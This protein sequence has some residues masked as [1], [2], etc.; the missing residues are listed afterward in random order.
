[1]HTSEP[2]KRPECR[3]PSHRVFDPADIKWV[4][5]NLPAR[6]DTQELE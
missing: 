5:R 1:M 4:R 6:P 3:L 2:T